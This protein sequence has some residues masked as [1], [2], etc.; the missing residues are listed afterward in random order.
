MKPFWE[1]KTFWL[2]V[3]AIAVLVAD[4][5]FTN[6]IIPAGIGV[7]VLGILNIVLRFLTSQPLS[8]SKLIKD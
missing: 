5:L 6:Q 4:Y 8:G 2:N 3:I 1:S 7:L